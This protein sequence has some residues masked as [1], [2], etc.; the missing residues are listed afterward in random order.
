MNKDIP[1]PSPSLINGKNDFV[2]E[3]KQFLFNHNLFRNEYQLNLFV[4]YFNKSGGNNKHLIKI[5]DHHVYSCVIFYIGLLC[6]AKNTYANQT[7]EE[8]LKVYS[9]VK[10]DSDVD[11]LGWDGN[12][13]IIY[14]RST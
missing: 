14:M 4:D 2:R 9:E 13:V 12:E 8:I 10:G 5:K 11:E 1:L 3:I 6:Y 7:M